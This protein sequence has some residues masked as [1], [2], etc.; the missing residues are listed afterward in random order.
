MKSVPVRL[1]NTGMAILVPTTLKSS[2]KTSTIVTTTPT[3]IGSAPALVR[4]GNSSESKDETKSQKQIKS[5]SFPSTLN[6][7]QNIVKKCLGSH[8]QKVSHKYDP[9]DCI[10]IE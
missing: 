5:Q 7:S 3:I 1:N 2:P 6:L 8:K 4:R 10:E 9:T